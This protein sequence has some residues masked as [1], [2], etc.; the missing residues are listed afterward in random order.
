[1]LIEFVWC[2]RCQEKQPADIVKVMLIEFVW[3]R[4]R[5]EKQS[6]DIVRVMLIGFVWCRRCQEKQSA[7]W[8]DTRMARRANILTKPVSQDICNSQRCKYPD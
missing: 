6:A 4:R 3:C 2:R 7:A 5:Q 8:W 1:M